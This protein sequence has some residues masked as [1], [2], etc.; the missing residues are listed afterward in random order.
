MPGSKHSNLLA[1][2]TETFTGSKVNIKTGL[3]TRISGVSVV[4]SAATAGDCDK[5]LKLSVAIAA[6]FKSFSIYAW[7]AT[8]GGNVALTAATDA[9]TVVWQAIGE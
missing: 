2:G 8:A 9:I 7:K 4:Q 6:D 1:F 5:A 3:L